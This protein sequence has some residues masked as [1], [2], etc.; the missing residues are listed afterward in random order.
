MKRLA[1]LVT[2]IQSLQKQTFTDY[3][4]IIVLEKSR[5]LLG[6]IDEY[7]KQHEYKNISVLFN[8][9]LRGAAAARNLGVKN[10]RGKILAFIDDDAVAT[11]EWLA[12][13]A[14]TSEHARTR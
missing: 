7:V 1:D 2:L 5:E 4:I 14:T 3:E 11:P 13:I 8:S 6:R 9:S 10:A 12:G